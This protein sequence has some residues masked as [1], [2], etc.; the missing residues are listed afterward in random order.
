MSWICVSKQPEPRQ[1][2]RQVLSMYT[3]TECP[4]ASRKKAQTSIRHS[5]RHQLAPGSVVTD[6]QCL[7]TDLALHFVL[8]EGAGLSKA[9][10][11]KMQNSTH[12]GIKPAQDSLLLHGL[13]QSDVLSPAITLS[14]SAWTL[15]QL[16]PSFSKHHCP[17]QTQFT[18]Q[19]LD[20]PDICRYSQPSSVKPWCGE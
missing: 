5:A 15:I 13:Q 18:Q 16:D 1:L 3:C 6:R 10:H 8:Q 11:L 9:L 14:F 7:R 12:L 4:V 19:G 2:F 20:A 17:I